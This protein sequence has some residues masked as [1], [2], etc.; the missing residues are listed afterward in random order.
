MTGDS[1]NEETS[2]TLHRN[3]NVCTFISPEGTRRIQDRIKKQQLF[4]RY[5]ILKK[6]TVAK[7]LRQFNMN[8]SFKGGGR[9]ET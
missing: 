3:L 6:H 9:E 5:Q 1:H 4:N 2:K 8:A 7:K